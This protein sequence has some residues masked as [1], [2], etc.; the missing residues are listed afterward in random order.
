MTRDIRTSVPSKLS[1]HRR[2]SLLRKVS[3]ST[4]LST[5]MSKAVRV[6]SRSGV[7]SLV[8]GGYAV[9]ENGYARFTSDVDIVVPDIQ[10]ARTRLLNQGFKEV[11]MSDLTVIDQMTTVR[12]K[13]MP[14]GGSTG[15]GP[16]QLPMPVTVANEPSIAD[17]QTL[18][19]MK[20]S[21]YVGSPV[22]RLKDLADVA[23]LM[24]ANRTPRDFKLNSEVVHEY[25]QVWDGLRENGV[26]LP[27][28][29]NILA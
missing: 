24:K 17:L 12:V 27:D 21:S 3:A 19:E 23:E 11:P 14:G 18:L 16:I 20:L 7:P 13:L 8:V 1:H 25:Q 15:P 10:E 26:S 28:P 5:T 22:S 4:N 2:A 6:L 9:Q 29:G